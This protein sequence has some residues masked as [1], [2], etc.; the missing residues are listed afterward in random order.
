MEQK[1]Y[2][3]KHCGKIATVVA[4]SKAPLFCCGE[5]MEELKA[6]TTDA[7]VEKHVPVYKI[8]NNKITVTVGETEH[9]MQPE[10]YI[11]WVSIKTKQGCQMKKLAPDSKPQVCFALCDTDELEA[12]YAYCNLH[13][14]WKAEKA[15]S[16]ANETAGASEKGNYTVCKCNN[17]SYYDIL[18]EIHKNSSIEGL[19]NMFEDVKDTTRCTTGC[20][21]C[22]DKVM[23]IISDEMS[24]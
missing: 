23:A 19:M 13:G 18:D 14:L 16:C 2:I 24:R 22:Y 17:V 11:E 1:F 9:P 21:G 7:A 5:K 15:A 4:D 3:C 10:H 20:G 8:D 6:N 12:V